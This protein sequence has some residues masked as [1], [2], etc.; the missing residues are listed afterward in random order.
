MRSRPTRC[1]RQAHGP[2]LHRHRTG[3]PDFPPVACRHHR[4]DAVHRALG[5]CPVRTY[6]RGCASR[7]QARQPGRTPPRRHH[8][9]RTSRSRPSRRDGT[10]R[11]SRSRCRPAGAATHRS[12][13]TGSR[14]CARLCHWLARWRARPWS[15]HRASRPRRTRRCRIGQRRAGWRH[16]RR[17]SARATSLRWL[18]RRR[19]SRLWRA[20]GWSC[21]LP[22]HRRTDSPARRSIANRRTTRGRIRAI[23]AYCPRRHRCRPTMPFAWSRTRCP[24]LWLR[25]HRGLRRA[26]RPRADRGLSRAARPSLRSRSGS[27]TAARARGQG[28]VRARAGRSAYQARRNPARVELP[29]RVR[30]PLPVAMASRTSPRRRARSRRAPRPTTKAR[31][32]APRRAA[33]RRALRAATGRPVRHPKPAIRT[34]WRPAARSGRRRVPGCAGPSSRWQAIGRPAA[35]RSRRRSDARSRWRWRLHGLAMNWPQSARRYSAASRCPK[36][37]AG[38]RHSAPARDGSSA[39]PGRL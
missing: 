37:R 28:P 2:N 16:R 11:R 19:C 26:A 27:R 1:V 32:R 36:T 10:V 30:S 4:K 17:Q 23:A 7:C 31:R 21:R 33:I 22:A 34:R 35:A 25:A 12:R 20:A 24:G 15:G 6:R 3:S 39:D 13:S 18:A 38:R 29:A 8:R 5:P 14:H 9:V